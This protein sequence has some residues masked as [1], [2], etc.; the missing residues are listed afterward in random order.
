MKISNWD[1]SLNF[2]YDIEMQKGGQVKI[3]YVYS[4]NS[5]ATETCKNRS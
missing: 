1:I 3:C 4:N 2:G 5:R